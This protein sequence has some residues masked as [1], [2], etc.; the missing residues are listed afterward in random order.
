MPTVYALVTDASGSAAAAGWV[1]EHLAK[2]ERMPARPAVEVD[3]PARRRRISR[4]RREAVN[5]DAREE[6][7]P[8]SPPAQVA[9]AG[10]DADARSR[11]VAAQDERDVGDRRRRQPAGEQ[12][13]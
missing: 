9:A 3:D 4:D 6:T 13:H 7:V 2:G 10:A 11:L 8:P 12:D 1:S 5:V